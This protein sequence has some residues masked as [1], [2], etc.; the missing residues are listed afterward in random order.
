MKLPFF[1]KQTGQE[2]E[3]GGEKL[4][5]NPEEIKIT[6]IIAPSSVQVKETFLRLGERLCQSFFVFSY[7]RYLST[8]WFSPAVNLN[9]QI[10][11]SLHIHPV[12]SGEVLRKLRKKLT[13]VQ[14]EIEEGQEKG[15]I[16]DPT[17]EIAF[18]DIERLRDD[19][20]T[21]RERIFRTGLYITIY[22]DDA[23][24]L[25]ETET[26]IR[27]I[28]ESRLIYIKP[29]IMQE[30][31]GFNSTSPC[32][33][34]QIMVHTP[35]NTAP[36]SSIFPFVSPDLSAN[37]GILY[38]INMHNN[39]LVLFDRFTLPNANLVVFAKS[40]SG[41]SYFCK[42]ESLRYLMQGVDVIIIDPEN[43]YDFLA[44][45]VGGSYFR[46]S[47]TSE[48]HLNPF[49]LPIPREDENPEDVLRSNVINLVG[50]LRIML[51]GL[52]PKED[53][54]IDQ[55]LT[56]TYAAKDITPE[57]DPKSWQEKIP[58][59]SDFE[60]V[61]EGMEGTESLVERV[62][63][64]TK[65]SYSQFF[66]NYSNISMDNNFVAF[67]IRNMEEELR[68]IAMFIILRYIW[69]QVRSNLK[70]RILLVDEAWVI[71]KKE[72]GASFLFG[73]CKRARKYWL[74]VSTITQD[75]SD[76]MKSVYGQP[77]I[78][79]SSLQFLMK[80][81]PATIDVVQ[82]TFNLTDQEKYLLLES[83]VG[84]G[85]FLAG[86]KRVALKVVAS[87]AED[88]V[89]T[90]SPEQVLKA[91]KAKEKLKQAQSQVSGQNQDALKESIEREE[92]QLP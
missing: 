63:K 11:L 26:L 40:G 52:T 9:C 58:L 84:E 32:G 49:D 13:E 39:S 41:K 24:S 59:M 37:E 21:A 20:Q 5:I 30:K 28:F 90:T 70:K 92:G 18:H 48:S 44:D 43:E 85:I 73:L 89:I 29:A 67:G 4:E 66:N 56:E 38:G 71:M 42:L 34:D 61:L 91:R 27:S 74:G 60:T 31:E 57:S 15:Y 62:R 72:D 6:D 46:V 64:F 33:L 79:N 86:R 87:Y 23:K 88:Q 14:A 83:A 1:K 8:G 22:G 36:L 7:P 45:A 3:I 16:R 2:I 50:L 25:S 51:G 19:L 78:T 35:M 81:S 77:I 80:Q 82:K 65:G 68:P 55:A 75:V 17:L 76:F 69:N 47:L 10:D 12:D 53:A 54:I